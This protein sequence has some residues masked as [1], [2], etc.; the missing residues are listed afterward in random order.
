MDFHRFFFLKVQCLPCKVIKKL[1]PQIKPSNL[2]LSPFI[3]KKTKM[4]S[5]GAT[6]ILESEGEVDQKFMHSF[7]WEIFIERLIY[8]R[9]YC[10]RCKYNSEQKG[11]PC[12]HGIYILVGI[13]NAQ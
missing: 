11:R 6:V 5:L 4:R 7:S 13:E 9:H 1:Y 12:S 3:V 8:L 2:I 10:G